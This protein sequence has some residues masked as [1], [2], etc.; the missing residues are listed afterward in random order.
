MTEYARPLDAL[1]ANDIEGALQWYERRRGPILN[2]PS[3]LNNLQ[4][5]ARL[6]CSLGRRTEALPLLDRL[7]DNEECAVFV[8]GQRLIE[9]G[10]RN[11]PP[12]AQLASIPLGAATRYRNAVM[13]AMTEFDIF[14]DTPAARHIAIAGISFCGSTIMDIILEGLP[15]VASI[16]ESVWLTRGWQIYFP[17]GERSVPGL[18]GCNRCGADCEYLTPNFRTALGLNPTDW[19]SR[20]AERLDTRLLISSD[21][22]LV[23]I[24][25]ND[26]KLNFTALVLF[27]SPKQAWSSTYVKTS[28]TYGSSE[29][30]FEGMIKFMNVWKSAYAEILHSFKPLGGKVFV[31]FDRFSQEPN[32]MFPSIVRALKL[33]YDPAAL[34]SPSPGHSLGGNS[35]AIKRVHGAGHRVAIYPLP[36]P[37]IP[38][39]HAAW[40]DGESDLGEL[41]RALQAASKRDLA[42][43]A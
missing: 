15:G 4:S 11:L 9:A 14:R 16:G 41:H 10:R 33:E 27:K 26:P 42:S 37:A 5:W 6:L 8:V 18:Q 24:I 28:Q 17:Y 38:A 1:V 22:N 21:K 2:E 25:Q 29:A 31:D 7:D 39:D 23:K 40:I 34:L 3:H 32:A 36:E 35:N 13:A 12:E 30:A 20:V 43:V 19:Y